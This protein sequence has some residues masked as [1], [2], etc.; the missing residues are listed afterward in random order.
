MGAA[1]HKRKELPMATA[2]IK[3]LELPAVIQSSITF[4]RSST[5]GESLREA[6]HEIRNMVASLGLYCD[7]LESPGVLS[8]VCQHY[9]GELRMVV[10]SGYR[11]VDRLV[12]LAGA[13]PSRYATQPQPK[14]SG[15]TPDLPCR[16]KSTLPSPTPRALSAKFVPPST[17]ANASRPGAQSRNRRH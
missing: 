16:C 12:G 2:E 15:N 9:G 8:P 4:P 6:A 1:M 11:L 5:H 3:K 17:A 14:P 13:E 10:R 7:L